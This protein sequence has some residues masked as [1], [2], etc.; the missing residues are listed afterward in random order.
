MR[1]SQAKAEEQ[2]Q[3]VGLLCRDT[4]ISLSQ[5]VYIPEK[6]PI[7]DGTQ[8][9]RT[10]AKRMLEAYIAAELSGSSN[11]TLRKYAKA[12]NDLGNELTHKR[13]ATLKD[14]AL[15]VNATLGLINLIGILENRH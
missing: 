12:A 9:S 1:V 15:C 2:F 14:A 6:H 3:A 7:T 10:D 4:I 8:V 11:E 5:A 13:T